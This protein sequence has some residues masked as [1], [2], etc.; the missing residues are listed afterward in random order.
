MAHFVFHSQR[1]ETDPRFERSPYIVSVPENEIGVTVGPFIATSTSCNDPVNLELLSDNTFTCRDCRQLNPLL[2]AT[3]PLLYSK[4]KSHNV[5]LTAYCSTNI[6]I[7]SWVYVIV[8]VVPTPTFERNVYNV[9]KSL[10]NVNDI[11]T[12]L[13]VQIYRSAVRYKIERSPDADSFRI[14]A[15][16]GTIRA[17]RLL[18]RLQYNF[19]VTAIEELP[20]TSLSSILATRP[21]SATILVALPLVRP[22]VFHLD[23]V[24]EVQ[25]NSYPVQIPINV[26][27]DS[28]GVDRVVVSIRSD[29]D[30]VFDFDSTSRVL[31]VNVSSLDFELESWKN[32]SVVLVA[33]GRVR[34]WL[35]ANHTLALVLRDVNDNS[36]V[37][38]VASP[39]NVTIAENIAINETALVVAATDADSGDNGRIAFRLDDDDDESSSYFEISSQTGIVRVIRRFPPRFVRAEYA[40]RV[41]ATDHGQ[42]ARNAT[43]AVFVRL[44]EVNEYAPQFH[45][46]SP[47][48]IDENLPVGSCV[49]PLNVTD[50]D[51]DGVV[52]QIVNETGDWLRVSNDSQCLVTNRTLDYETQ[53]INERSAAFALTANDTGNPSLS[54]T[55]Y[56]VVVL[57]DVN[58]NAPVFD[59]ASPLN[60]TIAENIAINETALVVVATDADSGDNGRIT[61]RLDDDDDESSSYFNIS[62]QTGIVRVI[63]RFPP[64]FVRAE[65]AFRVTATDHG[66]PAR[67]ASIAVFVRLAEVN[68]YAPRFHLLS[69]VF[70]DENLPVGSCVVPLNVT[71]RDRDGVVVRIVNETSDWL[72]VSNDS[73][74]LVINRTLDYETERNATFVLTA[75]DTGNPSL[76]STDYVVVVVLRDVNDNA[77]VFDVA[78]PLN[79][80]IAENIAINETALVVVATD[81]D[82][83]DNGRIT[84]RLDDDDDESSSYFNIS[85]QTG[86]VRVIR[87]F[88]PRFVRAEYAFRVTAIDHGQPARNASI[89]VFVRLAEVNEYAPRFHL[90][91]PVFIDENL[92]V[93]S[94]VVPLNVT[95]RDRDGV[96]VRIANETGNWLRVSNDSRC[97]VTN[98][99]LDYETQAIDERNATFVLTANDTGNPSLASR[100]YV[101]VVLRD[102][103]DNAP[104]FD[105]ASP[106]NV[107]I[108]ENIA[109]NETALVVV[110]TD[111]DSGDNGRI[112][113]R[114]DEDDDDDESSSYFNISSQ[115]GI[116]R[117]IR[118]FPPRFVRA[119]YAF[120]VTAIDHG[121]PA[122]NASIAV[123]VRLV[124]VNEYAPKF[125]LS[126][127]VFLDENLPVGSC[128][129]PLNV[130]DR[131]RDSVVVRIVNK[132]PDWLRVSND[133]RCLVTNRIL[134]YEAQA[135]D[136]RNATF[137]LTA[138]DTGSPSLASTDFVVVDVV[139][140]DVN[141]N[142]PAFVA[143]IAD[144]NPDIDLTWNATNSTYG[145]TTGKR[146]ALNRPLF[147][148]RATDRDSGS[149][150]EIVYYP[151]VNSTS[152][153]NVTST[154]NVVVTSLEPNRTWYR[155]T[156]L[157]V[158]GG[159]EKR[160]T[161]TAYVT[162][163]VADA[164]EF[165][166]RDDRLEV[167]EGVNETIPFRVEN[168][169]RVSIVNQSG[170]WSLVVHAAVGDYSLALTKP[171]DYEVGQRRAEVSLVATYK[172]VSLLRTEVR[173][174]IDVKDVNEHSPVFVGSDQRNIDISSLS[175]FGTTVYQA[176]ATDDDGSGN[177]V[178]YSFGSVSRLF[179]VDRLTGNVT[180]ATRFLIVC[181]HRYDLTAIL[182]FILLAWYLSTGLDCN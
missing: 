94:C 142:A 128:V 133:S 76:S 115:T 180:V 150:G 20:S 162:V 130:T 46:S 7:I 70:I 134:D 96:V 182:H 18:T 159:V 61:F 163:F 131:D 68:E 144:A 90:L 24:V 156:V 178:A 13:R 1:D 107:T 43:I 5:N 147:A 14:D 177:E 151:D 139:L 117:V 66:Q 110:A 54:S 112:T 71:D 101:V 169:D 129:V 39:L 171:F 81:A 64:Q 59:V 6:K 173:L 132:A 10:L 122:R 140:R 109:I 138:N 102:V 116:V 92:P 91:S 83:G 37:F 77:P 111:A 141:D 9:T 74:C 148:V 155:L 85:P 57:R 17:T 12:T 118:R 172:N 137:V 158:D 108:A 21:G 179:S 145:V 100:D 113:F 146:I 33:R 99:T 152:N 32:R 88:P 47:V 126:S 35:V 25:E 15:E 36:P 55:D 136:E 166:F 53:A 95:D 82:G 58:D 121:Q 153:L 44:A 31:T 89:A 16:N 103:N 78:S 8:D 75:N 38:D 42:P 175:R 51:R 63:R 80:T 168:A 98:R 181:M 56:V 105:V 87:R 149:N 60:V 30:G 48:F 22:P 52:V 69:P 106:L 174:T 41:T 86:I 62:P 119:E 161:G 143:P 45:L 157:A 4:R 124:E 19:T 170:S 28:D 73:R 123:F 93:G 154:G 114:L 2:S 67:N 125:H 23:D 160:L 50:R 167:D 120:R 79:V 135:I 27:Y 11:V 29:G 34:R 165:S 65:Y 3:K 26:T 49:V 164:P 72:R 104:V 176:S 40:L 127:P 84:F 97:L